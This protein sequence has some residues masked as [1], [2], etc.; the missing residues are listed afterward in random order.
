MKI[1][2]IST[3]QGN[4]NWERARKELDF[5]IFRSSVGSKQDNKYIFNAMNCGIPFGVYHYFK[6][7]TAEEAEKEAK[8][9]Y[10]CAT[11]EG[12]EPLFFCPDI[13]Y[14]TQ[15]SKTTKVVC[16]TI[17]DTLR[18]LGAKKVG[19]YIGQSRYSYI[20]DI[21]DY[22]DFIWIPR[23][24]KNTGEVDENYAPK[25]P[26]DIWQYTSMGHVDGIPTRVDLNILYGEKD[27]E[28]FIHN[29][30]RIEPPLKRSIFY[31]KGNTL[32]KNDNNKAVAELQLLLSSFGYLCGRKDGFFDDNTE[33]A[34]KAFQKDH[35]LTADGICGPKTIN[36]IIG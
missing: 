6:A 18:F 16:Q 31:L 12:L 29:G 17:L 35:G 5:V 2:D 24:G 11:Q 26:C 21:K 23:Y 15:T 4:I 3:Y 8:F 32:R 25:Y 33:K 34:L 27:L 9:F 22:F 7:G 19:L 28:W 13:E 1:A 20:R 30:L 14:E 10:E 36:K